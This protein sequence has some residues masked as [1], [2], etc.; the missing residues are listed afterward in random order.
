M[1]ETL[2]MRMSTLR[3]RERGRERERE[4]GERVR[5]VLQDAG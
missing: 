4:K 2:Y 1:S 3:P 5:G